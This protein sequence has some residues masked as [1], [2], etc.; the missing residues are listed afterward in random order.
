[1]S[2]VFTDNLSLSLDYLSKFYENPPLKTCGREECILSDP[3]CLIKC[4]LSRIRVVSS[5]DNNIPDLFEDIKSGSISINSVAGKLNDH[6][7]YWSAAGVALMLN[8]TLKSKQ[9]HVIG[10]PIF[11]TSPGS[12]HIEIA[13]WFCISSHK[14]KYKYDVALMYLSFFLGRNPNESSRIQWAKLKVVWSQTI[15]VPV[16]HCSMI[17]RSTEIPARGKRSV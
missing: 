9:P 15:I 17:R 13:F 8:H 10:K 7:Q 4:L 1:M 14:I 12:V 2:V 5:H 16:T 6:Q 11:E 3:T